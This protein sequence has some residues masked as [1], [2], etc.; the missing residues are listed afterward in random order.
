MALTRLLGK[1][2]PRRL[3]RRHHVF[4]YDTKTLRS[5][6]AKPLD[7][8]VGRAWYGNYATDYTTAPAFGSSGSPSLLVGL[9]RSSR[10]MP[11]HKAMAAATN[12]EE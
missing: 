4:Q 10:L 7:A 11:S 5:M 12:T 6:P 8:A 3:G 2:K 1:G 9:T